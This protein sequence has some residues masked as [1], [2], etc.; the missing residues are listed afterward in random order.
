[1]ILRIFILSRIKQKCVGSADGG[2][3][4]SKK[5]SDL[6]TK[7][8]LRN[9]TGLIV[10]LILFYFSTIVSWCFSV[11]SLGA[12]WLFSLLKFLTIIITIATFSYVI[13]V[14]MHLIKRGEE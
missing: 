3:K 14:E 6:T 8:L 10:L 13:R 12:L 9:K 4:V 1:M 5:L 7:E 2:L 11:V